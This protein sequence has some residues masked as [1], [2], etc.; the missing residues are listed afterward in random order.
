MKLIQFFRKYYIKERDERIICKVENIKCIYFFKECNVEIGGVIVDKL[1][2][3]YFGDQSV[4]IKCLCFMV[5]QKRK[6]IYINMDYS[7]YQ[8]IKLIFN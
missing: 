8:M 2:S 6:V 3:K 7:K 5:F 4:V 1:E